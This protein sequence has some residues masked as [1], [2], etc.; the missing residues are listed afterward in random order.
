VDEWRR[1]LR[2]DVAQARSVLQRVV[3]GRVTFTPYPAGMGASFRAETKFPGLFAG[4]TV[5]ALPVEL[6]PYVRTGNRRG[7][8]ALDAAERSVEARYE[9]LL[10]RAEAAVRRVEK[11]GRP[12]RDSNPR[13]SP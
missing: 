2:G 13:S 6:P 8:E 3:D 7:L 10:E 9:E 11:G 12:W 1:L 5:T 4:V